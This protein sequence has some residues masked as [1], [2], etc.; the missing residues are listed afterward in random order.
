MGDFLIFFFKLGFEFGLI[1]SVIGGHLLDHGEEFF[2]FLFVL[3]VVEQFLVNVRTFPLEESF[4]FLF[5]LFQLLFEEGDFLLVALI[6]LS[7]GVFELDVI[8]TKF[9]EFG[10]F[11][12]NEL[13]R[14]L[15]EVHFECVG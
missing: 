2:E 1:F 14:R 5:G 15:I 12:M 8:L 4:F 13:V 3:G 11:F 10:V 9:G 6:E 7:E